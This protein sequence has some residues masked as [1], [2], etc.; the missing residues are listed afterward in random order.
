MIIVVAGH[1]RGAATALVRAAVGVS[2]RT[3][4][5]AA[6][7]LLAASTRS[8]ARTTVGTDRCTDADDHTDQQKQQR[9]NGAHF[10]SENF[11]AME[12]R[13]NYATCLLVYN[14]V[15]LLRLL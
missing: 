13:W 12:K 1:S 15:I 8:V 10:C 3:T 6:I 5:V 2:E 7:L 4:A 11:E 14:Y 9:G